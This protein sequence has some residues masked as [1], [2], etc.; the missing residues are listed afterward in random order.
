M[1]PGM[2]YPTQVNL[3][4][5]IGHVG[6]RMTRLRRWRAAVRCVPT[7]SCSAASRTAQNTG[8]AER[9]RALAA[10][11]NR[12]YRAVSEREVV[13]E[14]GDAPSRLWL[15]RPSVFGD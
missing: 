4:F 12:H 14:I 11:P 10:E 7:T 9:Y 1:G 13:E 3:G 2:S 15:T 5:R 8:P 6:N